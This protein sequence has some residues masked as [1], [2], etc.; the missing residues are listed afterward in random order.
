MTYDPKSAV[1]GLRE[2]MNALKAK[3]KRH[4]IPKG[5]VGLDGAEISPKIE[6]GPA[7]CCL[8]LLAFLHKHP[9]VPD[10]FH[11][12]PLS[13]AGITEY[14]RPDGAI[15]LGTFE[16]PND[17]GSAVLVYG[18]PAMSQAQAAAASLTYRRKITQGFD[19]AIKKQHF[20]S[21]MPKGD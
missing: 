20:A 16:L 1:L 2:G 19:A 13:K 9:M 3:Q 4:A 18:D 8:L 6:T 10:D 12:V 7:T 21:I 5:I 11:N 14:V 17:P 15:Y